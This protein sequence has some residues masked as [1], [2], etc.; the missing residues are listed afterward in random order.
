MKRQILILLLAILTLYSANGQLSLE[1]VIYGG[2]TVYNYYPRALN[3]SFR[4]DMNQLVIQRN[5]SVMVQGIKDE[6]AS[7][8]FDLNWLNNILRLE[9]YPELKRLPALKW[10]TASSFSFTA[11]SGFFT[12]DQSE[13]QITMFVGRV[14]EGQNFDLNKDNAQ[15]AYTVGN[16]LFIQSTNEEP[17]FVAGKDGDD[18]IFGH[19]VHRNEFGINKGTFWSPDG[20]SLAFYREDNSMVS[21]YPLV[22]VDERVAKLENIK[23]PMAGMSSHQVTVGVYNLATKETTYLNTGAPYDRFFTNVCWTPDNQ[24]ILIAE[25]NREQ[26]HMQLKKYSAAT[27]ELVATLFEEKDDKWTEPQHP[28]LFIPKRKG[29]F[30]WQSMKDGYNHLYIYSLDGKLKKQLTKGNWEVTNVL[31]FDAAAKNIF[32]ESTKEEA[33]ERHIYKVSLSSGKMTRITSERGVHRAKISKDGRYAI[34]TFSSLNVPSKTNLKDTQGRLIKTLQVVDNPYKDI[35][36]GKVELIKLKTKDEQFELD[37]RMV[38]PV[39]FDPAKKYPV[40]VYVYGGPHSQMVQNRWLAGA[41]GWQLYMAQ[42]GYIAF[43]LDNRGT[44]NK[45]KV[46]AQAI[47]RQLG[48]LEVEDQMQG[49]EYLKSLPYVDT[50]RIGVHGWS[51]GGFMTISMMTQHPEVFKV[52][53]AGGPVIDWKYYEIMYG[54]RYMDTPQENPEGY[55]LAN[56]N[57][58]VTNIEGRLLVVHGAIDP[59]VVWQHSLSFVRECVKNRVQID[60]FAYPRHEHNVIGRDRIHLMEKVTRYFDDFL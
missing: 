31:G 42:K 29:E 5:D 16:D 7:F 19:T 50:E 38:L 54:E 18:V 6:K 9:E 8:L 26:N 13:G 43:T 24:F 40:I 4:G 58:K 20:G 34:T 49:I 60:Y 47:H 44:A 28:A 11:N 2:K 46:F 12:I 25:L 23:Y 35:E 45:G 27:G 3:V 1:D 51:Y 36:T 14:K 21:D 32:I 39:G 10:E 33:L 56:L 59:V 30:I 52:G 53:V 41:R 17:V 48:Q 15:V 22:N 55:E 57:G 37:A